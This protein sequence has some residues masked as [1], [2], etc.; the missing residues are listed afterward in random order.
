MD[1]FDIRGKRTTFDNRQGARDAALRIADG[2]S[3]SA[4]SQIYCRNCHHAWY[5]ECF[6]TQHSAEQSFMRPESNNS[7]SLPKTLILR[8]ESPSVQR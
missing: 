8:E 3:D 7:N 6:E 5:V 4:G 1:G 2:E